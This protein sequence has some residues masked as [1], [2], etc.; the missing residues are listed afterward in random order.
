[1]TD[2]TTTIDDSEEVHP[3]QFIDEDEPPTVRYNTLAYQRKMEQQLADE[4]PPTVRT[5]PITQ[6]AIPKR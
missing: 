3:H 1:M 5:G 2:T 4:V 6:R